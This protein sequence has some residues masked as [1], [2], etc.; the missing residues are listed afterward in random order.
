MG[1]RRD[2]QPP[3]PIVMPDRSSPT[4]SA[5]VMT[6]PDWP[7]PSA[8]P[9][10]PGRGSVTT[11]SIDERLPGPVG[12]PGQVQLEGKALLVAVGAAHIN[13]LDTVQRLLGQPDDL[14][15]FRRYFR[16][17]LASSRTQL[18]RGH[19][20]EDGAVLFQFQR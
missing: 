9:P 15:V 7:S 12:D 3:M 16:G 17:E 20:V 11:G 6:A 18:G 13:R 5:M 19:D 1:L 14:A 2:P 4:T 8:A 10:S